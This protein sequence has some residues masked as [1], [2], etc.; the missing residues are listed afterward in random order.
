MQDIKNAFTIGILDVSP[1]TNATFVDPN[2]VIY[3]RQYPQ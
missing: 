2:A 1:Y 3:A